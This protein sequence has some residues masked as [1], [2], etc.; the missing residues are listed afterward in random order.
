MFRAADLAGHLLEVA[1]TR[2]DD[3]DLPTPCAG[4]T[5]RDL[6]GHLV[7]VTHRVAHIARGGAPFDLPSLLA[8]EPGEGWAAA[9]RAG[10]ADL[11]AAWA[12]DSV[13]A[14][15]V[16]HPAG[17]MPGAA[18]ATIYAQE[19]TTHAGDLAV[20]LARPELLDEDLAATV[21]A[22]AVRFVPAERPGFPFDPPVE[23]AADAPASARLAGWLG[24]APLVQE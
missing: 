14:T 24:R 18:A 6:V 3:L 12:E 4:W 23:V 21:L 5:V 8:A 22:D 9:Y 16:Q 20:A 7:A 17:P 19:F 1:T 15:L 11:R 2:N 10:V 13:L